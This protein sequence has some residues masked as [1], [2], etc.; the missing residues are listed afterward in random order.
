MKGS[1]QSSFDYMSSPLNTNSL[2]QQPGGLQP[3]DLNQH[4][5]TQEQMSKLFGQLS[6]QD[7]EAIQQKMSECT[8]KT[9]YTRSLPI[10]AIT[11]AC[12]HLIRQKYYHFGPKSNAAFLIFFGGANL[13]TANVYAMFSCAKLI[14]PMLTPLYAKYNSSG[15]SAPDK[16]YDALRSANRSSV[17]GAGNYDYDST[18]TASQNDESRL[19]SEW[20]TTES[21]RPGYDMKKPVHTNKFDYE[22]APFVMSGTPLGSN[23]AKNKY[24]DDLSKN[25]FE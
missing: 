9:M 20:G 13:L 14:P 17:G 6:T 18:R 5:L 10:A 24:G 8:S 22:D 3:V 16:S 2:P 11:T 1:E 4:K 12:M 21:P 7:K 23:G 19:S 15:T 25:K